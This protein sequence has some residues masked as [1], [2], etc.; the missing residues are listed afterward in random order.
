MLPDYETATL[1][2]LRVDKY[3]TITIDSNKYSVPD[4]FVGKF[5][6]A[7]IY[8]DTVSIIYENKKIATH[9]RLFGLNEWSIVIT[10]YKNTLLK[11]PGA[12]KGSL[13]FTSIEPK[14]QEIF[15][16]YFYDAPKDFIL[17]LDL[18]SEHCLND[19]LKAIDK[20]NKNQSHINL[21][22]IKLILER[23]DSHDYYTKNTLNVKDEIAEM[24]VEFPF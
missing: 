24:G 10:H 18:I 15:T 14:L 19:V 21:D 20:L 16:L 11:K 6:H 17:L 23:N 4:S 12:L 7:K 8:T 22:Y 1:K 2:E 13:A 5:V 9:R 3:C